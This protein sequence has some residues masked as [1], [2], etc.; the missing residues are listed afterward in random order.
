MKYI[1]NATKFGT[2]SRSSLLI[3]NMLF[4]VANL[5]AKLKTWVDWVSKL[6]C[7]QFYEIGHSELIEHAIYE[8][9]NWNS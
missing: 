6:Q 1:P 2:Q 3:I 9:I 8:D 4:K 5:D 7:A